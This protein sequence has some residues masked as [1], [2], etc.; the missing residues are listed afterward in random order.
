MDM[1]TQQVNLY[2]PA[3]HKQI[4][5]FSAM[6]SLILGTVAI[7]LMAAVYFNEVNSQSQLIEQIN[8]QKNLHSNVMAKLQESNQ[9]QQ[10]QANLKLYQEQLSQQIQRKQNVLNRL[11]TAGQS[12]QMAKPFSDYFTALASHPIKGLWIDEITLSDRGQQL[13][14][15][16]RTYNPKQVPTLIDRLKSDPNMHG[17]QFKTVTLNRDPENPAHMRFALLTHKESTHGQQ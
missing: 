8:H 17:A 1:P 6:H 9:G 3:F 14:L 2:Q 7:V 4:V 5:L 10:S 12:D 15:H 13:A 16:G 11:N